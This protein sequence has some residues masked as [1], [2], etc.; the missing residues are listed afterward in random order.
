MLAKAFLESQV[1]AGRPLAPTPV[2]RDLIPESRLPATALAAL[3]AAVGESQVLLDSMARLLHSRG[4]SY[5][6]MLHRRGADTSTVPAAVLHPTSHDQVLEVL[7]ICVEHRISVVPYGGG[8]SVVGGVTRPAE[9]IGIVIS[10]DKL[11][12]L[13]ALD[14]VSGL[15]RVQPGMTGPVLERLLGARGFTLGHLPQSWERASIGGYAATR[16][17]GQAST[18]YGRI[19]DMIE[20][21]TLATPSGTWSAG[22]VPASAAGPNL[23]QLALGSEGAF[24]VITEI[25]LRVR[26]LAI[27]RRYEGAIAPCFAAGI[28]A[29]RELAQLGLTSAV[30]RLSDEAETVATLAMSGPTGVKRKIF[31][32]YLAARGAGQGALLIMGWEEHSSAIL[33][34]RRDAA[35]AVLKKF[36]VVSLGKGVGSTWEHGRYSG[37]YLRDTL[38]D[39]GYLVETF[40]TAT[41]WVELPKLH[42]VARRAALA[43]LV[44]PEHTPYVMSHISHVYET[45]ASLYFTVIDSGGAGSIK[46]WVA[47]KA[48]ISSALHS[49]GGTITHHHAIGRDHAPWLGAEVG[50]VGMGLLRAIKSELD[51]TGIMNPGVL[52]QVA[53]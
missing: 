26:R 28:D 13:V 32:R 1:G 44:D 30:I 42:E 3:I 37:P 19:D 8:T 5:V 25:T 49:A 31:D 38:L 16:S 53:D 2:A 21:V 9:P 51:P 7:R 34:A 18:G 27:A 12:A 33:T 22:R 20:S 15:V 48:A 6:D 24:G 41:S 47:A 43:A 11:S 45:G 17:A 23:M 35:W 14:E 52:I 36:G 10:L 39:S 29:C 46:R 50:P 4:M 40:E